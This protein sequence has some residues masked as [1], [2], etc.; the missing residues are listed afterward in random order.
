[1]TAYA[2]LLTLTSAKNVPAMCVSRVDGSI[3]E[4]RGGKGRKPYRR[5]SGPKVCP[6]GCQ[7]KERKKKA[8][9]PITAGVGNPGLRVYGTSVN[10]WLHFGFAVF[11]VKNRAGAS[12]S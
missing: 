2:R 4:L 11:F 10:K 1:M 8:G 3:V 6:L 5:W 9:G 12:R 7:R